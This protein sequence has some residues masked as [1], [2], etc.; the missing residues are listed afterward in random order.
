MSIEIIS[1]FLNST[2]S[3]YSPIEFSARQCKYLK[4]SSEKKRAKAWNEVASSSTYRVHT[5]NNINE[6][7]IKL[8][9]SAQIMQYAMRST[10]VRN[11]SHVRTLTLH[12][13]AAMDN[14]GDALVNSHTRTCTEHMRE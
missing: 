11:E 6:H 14:N 1:T 7:R 4:E 2:N 3:G 13:N 8:D 9:Q 5:F 12:L 10:R